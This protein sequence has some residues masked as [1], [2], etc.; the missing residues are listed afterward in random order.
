MKTSRL[1]VRRAAGRRVSILEGRSVVSI[2]Q[3]AFMC[4]GLSLLVRGYT[5][6]ARSGDIPSLHQSQGS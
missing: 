3:T 4:M 5:A 1:S 6:Q 2:E